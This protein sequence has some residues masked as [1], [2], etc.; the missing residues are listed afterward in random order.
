MDSYKPQPKASATRN[1]PLLVASNVTDN[2]K[3]TERQSQAYNDNEN[4]QK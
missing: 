2:A 4:K 1:P 3:D